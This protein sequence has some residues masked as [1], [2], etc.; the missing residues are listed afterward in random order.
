MTS[1]RNAICLGFLVLVLLPG[2]GTTRH[3]EVQGIDMP[4]SLELE[5]L[6][7]QQ[8]MVLA[9][10][11]GEGCSEFYAL[12]PLPIFWTKS[13]NVSGGLYGFASFD[14]ARNVAIYHAIENV[15]RADG[16]ISPRYW[17]T[18]KREGIWYVKKCVVVKA[19]AFSIKP[20]ETMPENIA[21]RPPD[22]EIPMKSNESYD[23]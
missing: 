22:V 18:V 9:D 14:T 2:C 19:K 16:L 15:P 13:E 7:R 1:R 3:N 4:G 5:P 21:R 12:W 17:S 11:E 23:F 20:D 10:T 6:N 8:Y